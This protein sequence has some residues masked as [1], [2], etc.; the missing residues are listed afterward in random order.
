MND[1]VNETSQTVAAGQLRR[2]EVHF[3]RLSHVT[4][5]LLIQIS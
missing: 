5:S 2:K 3:G 4:L 1:V